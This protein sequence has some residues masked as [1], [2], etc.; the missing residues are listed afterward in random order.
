MTTPA[1]DVPDVA[2]PREVVGGKHAGDLA[3]CL[4][5]HSR[6]EERGSLQI[7]RQVAIEAAREDLLRCHTRPLRTL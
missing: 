4:G 5:R 1:S 6:I 3:V 2:K 7:A